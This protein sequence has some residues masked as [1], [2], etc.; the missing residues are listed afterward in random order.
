[1]NFDDILKCVWRAVSFINLPNAVEFLKIPLKFT[2][3]YS[4]RE[5]EF[6]NEQYLLVLAV[7]LTHL[8]EHSNKE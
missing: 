2:V 5:L 3:C 7:A 8:F 1:M 4:I 6:A